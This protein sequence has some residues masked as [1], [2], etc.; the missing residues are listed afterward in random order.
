MKW[1]IPDT[2]WILGILHTVEVRPF[3]ES[4]LTER[5]QNGLYDSDTRTISIDS[6]VPEHLRHELFCHEVAEGVNDIMDLG[7]KHYQI[8]AIG[9]GFHDVF[10]N[11][12]E[13]E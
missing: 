8:A 12:M 1:N 5:G 11:Q 3:N 2:V 13:A 10:R 6:V 7:L 4:D 9:V